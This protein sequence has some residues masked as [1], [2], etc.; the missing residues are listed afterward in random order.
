MAMYPERDGLEMMIEPGT[1]ARDRNT[2]VV[3]IIMHQTWRSQ[4]IT[5]QATRNKNEWT[6]ATREFR[7]K[8]PG[9]LFGVSAHFT[10]ETDGRIY[11]HVD[12]KDGAM[13]THDYAFNS[14]HIEFA[15]KNDPL[16]NDQLF[17]GAD[18]MAWIASVHPKVKLTVVG[19][20]NSD[21][22]DKKQEG[23]TCHS[24]V[25][26]VGKYEKAKLACPGPAIVAQMNQIAVL[27]SVRALIR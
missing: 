27:S 8:H 1:F 18:L 15:S 11:Q 6:S 19:T 23:I 7:A 4:T 12:T 22:G 21:P 10:V 16:T 9:S 24:F 14:V 20:S 26:I 3:R 17:Y 5:D 25:E 2:N 13:G